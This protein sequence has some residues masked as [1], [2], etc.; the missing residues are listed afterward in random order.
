[1][2]LRA[3][4]N[5]FAKKAHIS[6][7]LALQGYFIERFLARVERSEF[8]GNLAVKGGTLMC[9]LL[10]LPQR[11]TMD[12]DATVFGVHADE[13]AIVRIVESVAA[14]DAGDGVLFHRDGTEPSS[15][16]KDDDYG[17][18][19][20]G[21]TAEFGTI[22]L[23]ISVDVTFG[24]VI[25]PAP[26]LRQFASVLDE[27]TVIRILAYP[28]ETLMAEKIQSI[29]KR[30]EGT[31][32]PRDFYDLHMLRIR[33]GYNEE[34]LKKAVDNT[35][36]NRNSNEYFGKRMEILSTI[37][38]SSFQRQ[39]WDRYRKKYPYAQN[40]RF[41]ELVESLGVLFELL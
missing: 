17:G 7:Q 26:E 21:L 41:D 3:R 38:N 12:I 5:N 28:V 2:S 19:S 8:A 39:Q 34:I 22:R 30:G 37:G 36:R 16:S 20:I 13:D 31:T 15:I 40:I 6:P 4:M 25:T 27:N 24:D 33:G 35:L 11:T 23:P 14:I 9:A 29:L 18:F 10:G 32:R 1:M